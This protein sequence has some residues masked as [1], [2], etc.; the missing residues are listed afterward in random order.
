MT[1][2][3]T[4]LCTLLVLYIKIGMI[5]TA[6]LLIA[7]KGKRTPELCAIYMAVGILWPGAL[8]LAAARKAKDEDTE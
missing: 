4:V 8:L 1:V 2:V 3:W 7:E 6:Y 5:I